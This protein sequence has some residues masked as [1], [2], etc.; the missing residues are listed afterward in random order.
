MKEMVIKL[1]QLENSLACTSA[2]PFYFAILSKLSD[3]ILV[4]WYSKNCKNCSIG[5]FSNIIYLLSNK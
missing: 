5:W 4:M 3:N 1:F 2:I